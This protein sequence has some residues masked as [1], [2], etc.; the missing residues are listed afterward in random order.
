MNVSGQPAGELSP[1][2]LVLSRLDRVK[3][4]A[5]GGAMARCPG[6]D[7]STASLKINEAVDGKAMH[8]RPRRLRDRKDP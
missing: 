8:F 1:Y 4:W 3:R 6:H 7:D 2:E 5:S